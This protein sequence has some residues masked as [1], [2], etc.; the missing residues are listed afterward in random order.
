MGLTTQVAV[1]TGALFHDDVTDVVKHQV[2]PHVSPVLRWDSTTTQDLQ[3]LLQKGG[4]IHEDINL[5][6]NFIGQDHIYIC[7]S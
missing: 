1:V 2:T 5:H 6:I 3:L 7:C 4:K